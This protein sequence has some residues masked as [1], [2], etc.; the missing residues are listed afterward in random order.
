M[1]LRKFITLSM[2]MMTHED[3]EA[4]VHCC[5]QQAILIITAIAVTITGP[6]QSSPSTV[7]VTTLSPC[8]VVS[9]VDD[10]EL[11]KETLVSFLLNPKVITRAT[12]SD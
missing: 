7:P 8:S 6:F 4:D 3:D 5:S 12:I 9:L 11:R 10:V 2:R 1:I